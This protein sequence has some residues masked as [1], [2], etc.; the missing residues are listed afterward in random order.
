M[1]SSQKLKTERGEREREREKRATGRGGGPA[2]DQQVC[3]GDIIVQNK[4]EEPANTTETKS[5]TIHQVSAYS[6]AISLPKI[7]SG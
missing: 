7:V 4:Q 5:A 2:A 3:A 1:K 6:H